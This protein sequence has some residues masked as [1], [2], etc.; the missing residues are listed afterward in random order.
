MLRGKNHL[1]YNSTSA[2]FGLQ[3][4]TRYIDMYVI[5]GQPRFE[6]RE[7]VSH[8]CSLLHFTRV[9]TSVEAMTQFLVG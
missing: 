4:H 1:A 8:V 9:K 7:K 5:A 2:T 6:W 3:T